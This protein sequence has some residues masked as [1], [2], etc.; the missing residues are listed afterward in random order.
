MKTKNNFSKILA[1]LALIGLTYST[2][3]TAS[4][5]ND[6]DAE[7]KIKKNSEQVATIK[8]SDYAAEV[9]ARIKAYSV[10][11]LVPANDP[12]LNL[13]KWMVESRNFVP[14]LIL[15]AEREKPANLENWMTSESNFSIQA[16]LEEVKEEPLVLEDWM[17]DEKCFT[18]KKKSNL[19]VSGITF[20]F[21]GK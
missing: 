1:A 18:C 4:E 16:M 11:D 9:A 13:E 2:T 15:T 21:D 14:T 19:E 5:A 20:N 10:F 7:G 8:A 17:L 6:K 12:T 3:A